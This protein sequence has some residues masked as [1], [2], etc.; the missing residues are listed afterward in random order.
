MPSGVDTH[1]VG[2]AEACGEDVRFGAILA[3]A[4]QGAVLRHDRFQGVASC[5]GVVEIPFRIG[6]QA[7]GELVEMFRHLMV[8]VEALV[9]VRFAVAVEIVQDHDL[10][11]AAHVDLLLNDLQSERLEE[12]R[13]DA[14]PGQPL[15]RGVDALNQPDVAVPGT[16]GGAAA[17]GIEVEAG[18]PHLA[19]PGIVRRMRQHVDRE[20]L[21]VAADRR[22]VFSALP[23]SVAG[24]PS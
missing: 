24:R 22:P 8:V 14:L 23:A 5:L 2:S 10:I 19:V 15:G 21:G 4:Q 11:A 12:T 17:I 18:Q 16:N 7:H 9:K 3:D 1:A 6:L 13:R 20:C